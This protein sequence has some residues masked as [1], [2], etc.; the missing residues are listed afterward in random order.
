MELKKTRRFCNRPD[1]HEPR[2][3]CGYPL[4][5]P[6]HTAVIDLEKDTI[7]VPASLGF[8]V[9][10]RLEKIRDAVKKEE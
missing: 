8:K 1:R 4:P 2:M 10:K 9:A 7:L 3:K 5:C 6:W